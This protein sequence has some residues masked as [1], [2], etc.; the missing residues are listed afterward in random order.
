V[1]AAS[2]RHIC[3]C[4]CWLPWQVQYDKRCDVYSYGILIWEIWHCRCPYAEHNCNQMQIA[5]LIW[6]DKIRPSMDSHMREDVQN[7]ICR[8][9]F[10][11]PS[12]LRF[13]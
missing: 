9:C 7:L 13:S 11:A 5:Y 1:A 8:S 3:C 2:L 6:K 4:C 12:V 10:L